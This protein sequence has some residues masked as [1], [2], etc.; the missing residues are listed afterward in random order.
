LPPGNRGQNFLKEIEQIYE[1]A[2]D[3]VERIYYYQEKQ[4]IDSNEGKTSRFI[5]L[6]IG[7]AEARRKK[8]GFRQ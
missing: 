3:K 6:Q 8:G 2:L 4:N 1:K 7:Y 5:K